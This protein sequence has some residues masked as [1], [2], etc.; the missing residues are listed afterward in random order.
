[1][2]MWEVKA[3]K[4]SFVQSLRSLI[5]ESGKS[6]QFVCRI[7]SKTEAKVNWYRD[8]TLIK[9]SKEYKTTFTGSLVKLFIEKTSIEHSGMYTCEVINEYGREESSAELIVRGRY[10]VS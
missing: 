6:A 2:N 10:S 9:D 1:M 4:P 5:V 3:E 8:K 7:E